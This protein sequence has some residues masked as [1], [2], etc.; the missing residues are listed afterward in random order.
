[1]SQSQP[2]ISDKERARRQRQSAQ[3]VSERSYTLKEWCARRSISLAMFHKMRAQGGGPRTYTV[4]RRR[5]ISSDADA[6]WLLA[7]EAAAAKA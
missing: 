5:F 7:R 1:M 2:Q 4:G 6:E 3:S